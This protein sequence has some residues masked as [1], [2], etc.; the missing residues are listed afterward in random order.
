VI[1]SIAALVAA[2][3]LLIAHWDTVK[4]YAVQSWE[5]IKSAVLTAILTMLQGM[6]NYLSWI[7]GFG[8][9]LK[10][11]TA[12]I[13]SA[14]LASTKSYET[15]K[16]TYEAQQADKALAKLKADG[17]KTLIEEKKT[18]AARKLSHEEMIQSFSASWAQFTAD[19]QAKTMD[20]YSQLNTLGTNFQS[21]LSAGFNTMFTNIKDGWSALGAGM[22]AFGEAIKTAIIQQLADMSAAWVMKHIIMSAATKLWRT[23]EVSANAAVAASKAAATTAWSLWGA[24]AIGALI[25]AAVVGLA[26]GFE[27]G[28]IVGGSSYTGDHVLAAVNSDEM[29][30]NRSQQARLFTMANG[31]EERTVINSSNQ[32]NTKE[33]N[34]TIIVQLDG[35]VIA[36][37]AAQ[38][39]PAV[40]KLYGVS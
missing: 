39:L 28:G 10:Q 12:S 22:K 6:T 36:Q 4:Y 5:F 33:I 8:N 31:R 26:G 3:Y 17:T 32:S 25:G 13:Q 34:Q 30:L 7:P 35:R 2:G 15:N 14:L 37:A 29:I 38:N 21:S 23:Q 27:T 9:Q 20:W 40:L 18:N 11:A 24:I 19:Y 16:A 1:G